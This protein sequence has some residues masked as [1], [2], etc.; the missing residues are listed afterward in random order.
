M[1]DWVT[2]ALVQLL[3]GHPDVMRALFERFWTVDDPYVVQRVVAIAFGSLLRSAPGQADQAKALARAVHARVFAR[4]IRPDELLLDAARG[5]TRWAVAHQLLPES[6]LTAAQRPYGLKPPGSPPTEATLDAKYGWREG[7]S[8]DESYSSIHSSVLSMGDFGR[9]V[10]ESGLRDFSRYRIG[11]EYPEHRHREPRFVRSKWDAFVASL[12]AEQQAALGERLNNPEH[13]KL[14]R[15]GC[16][17]RGEK[18]LLIDEQYKLL[19][20]AFVY[21]KWVN[22]E[23]P[24][25][26]ARRWVLRR[27][28]SLGWTPK[29]FGIRDRQ[30][31]H[32]RPGLEAHKVERW[33]KKYQ[34]MAYH[35][36]LA[37]V[38]DNFQASHRSDDD[39]PYEGL[40]QIIGEREI[41]PSLPPID[42][43]AFSEYKGAGAAAW[44]PPTIQ[45][46]AWPP[47]RLD[48][49]Q[50]QGDVR[51]FLADTASEPAVGNALFLRDRD[52]ND[53]VVLNSSIKQVD[54]LA[55]KGWR[56]LQEQSS[57]HTL[58]TTAGESKALLAALPENP[59]FEVQDLLDDTGHTDCCY[60]GEVGRTG[61][62]CY[63]RHDYLQQVAIRGTSFLAVPTVEQYA[64]EG[65]IL[66]CSIGETASTIL[67]STF[68]QQA[69]GLSLD[70]CGP[71]WLDAD[72]TP[73][74]MYFEAPGNDS[75]ALLV[76]A[77]FLRKFLADGKLEL[78]V[79]HWFERME[80]TDKHDSHHP[81]VDV[82]TNARLGSDMTIHA[83]K[84]PRT[85][86]DLT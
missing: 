5:I 50:Y 9:Y 37:R 7:Q 70:M 30:L 36:L 32:G 11:H 38:A 49:K 54:P 68:L 25:E 56:G 75:Q 41:D 13:S 69:A 58:L 21:P 57:I 16:I 63:H 76:R 64:W 42:F 40:H 55:H 53:W 6:A 66:D 35:E 79:L 59:R 67:P 14:S 72:G 22:H 52:G 17:M 48:F 44:E 15:L 43:R 3:R 23:Y 77:S 78:I 12:S 34:W 51:R 61:P 45:F 73:V 29:L 86:R 1:R 47:G 18:D 81:Q 84:H 60:V 65:N 24:T 19:D 28:L 62:I 20:A 71:S 10:V 85:E 2:K 82:T 83:G 27:T 31:E 46:A 39:V 4:P 8:D 26:V 80:L 74:F 33:G